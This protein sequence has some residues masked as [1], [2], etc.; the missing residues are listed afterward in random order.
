MVCEPKFFIAVVSV[1]HPVA[2]GEY[3]A[4]GINK[5]AQA[6]NFELPALFYPQ[7]NIRLLFYFVTDDEAKLFRA[8]RYQLFS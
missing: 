2:V 3:R 6:G 8:K 7:R 5:S 4:I 1:L